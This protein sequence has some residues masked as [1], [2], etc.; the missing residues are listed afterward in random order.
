MVWTRLD[1]TNKT[2]AETERDARMADFHGN[3]EQYLQNALD[4]PVEAF[5][6][7]Y[8]AWAREHRRDATLKIQTTFWKALIEHS[9]AYRMSQITRITLEE[10]KT[11]QLGRWSK[12][13]VNSALKDIRA[14][15]NRAIKQGWYSGP[16]PT[17]GI[18]RY[19]ITRKLPE[20][21]NEAEL[22]K[23]LEYAAKVGQVAEWTVLLGGWAGLRRKEITAARWEWFHFD[24]QEPIVEIK[25]F[26]GFDLKDSE[27]RTIA[28]SRRVFDAL[29][30]HRKESGFLFESGHK[31]EGKHRYRFEPRRQLFA[32]L[33]AAGLSTD[34]AFQRLRVSFACLHAMA[35]TPIYTLSKWLGHSS[36][37]VT[38]RY[39]VRAKG[40]SKDIDAF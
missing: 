39:Y 35:G 3:R 15:F 4:L 11:A 10:F 38:E 16:N 20:P 34:D 24:G 32:A 6:A 31:N 26:E 19:T 33:Q 22:N 1:A 12:A 29:Y 25:A 36:V 14:I 18:E 7:K 13:S 17:V 28:M 8:E 40:Y 9:G 27:E 23:L 37:T 30:P 5:W 2:D 21:H